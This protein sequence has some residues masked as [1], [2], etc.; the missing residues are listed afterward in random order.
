MDNAFATK[1]AG[2]AM[3]TARSTIVCGCAL[4]LALAG[5]L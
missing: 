5:I 2:Y 4:A 3:E 1:I